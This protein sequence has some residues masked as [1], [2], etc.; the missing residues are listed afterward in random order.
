LPYDR[1]PLV[2]LLQ[3][4]E[5]FKPA[6]VEVAVELIDEA[7]QKPERSTY[8]FIVAVDEGEGDERAYFGYVCF[9]PTPMTQ[10]TYDLYWIVV[11]PEHRG[12]GVGHALLRALAA[13]LAHNG[14]RILRVETSSSE[15]YRSA[16]GFYKREGF[17]EGGRIPNFYGDG[18]DLIIYYMVVEEADCT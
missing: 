9:G 12:K 2:A 14:G 5:G 15:M 7:L 10:H 11:D 6:D 8:R 3:R 17:I 16:K 18:D 1:E 4:I 13:T